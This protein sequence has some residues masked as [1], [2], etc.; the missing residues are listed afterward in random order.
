MADCRCMPE[1]QVRGGGGER[2]RGGFA[3]PTVPSRSWSTAWPTAAACLRSRRE[4]GGRV[5]CREGGGDYVQSVIAASRSKVV[6][7]RY[8]TEIR[9]VDRAA[10]SSL[11]SAAQGGKGKRGKRG[12]RGNAS[13]IDLSTGKSVT[14]TLLR[15]GSVD[16]ATRR[17]ALHYFVSSCCRCA[18]RTTLLMLSWTRARSMPCCVGRRWPRTA[19]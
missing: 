16:R 2:G 6:D 8:V 11:H 13:C 3:Q 1:I 14:L 9:S 15:S 10:W 7:Y 5:C 17:S 19:R 4:G 18:H 12:K